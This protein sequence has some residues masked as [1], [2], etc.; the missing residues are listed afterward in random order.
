MQVSQELCRL[1]VLFRLG[2]HGQL[3]HLLPRLVLAPHQLL[4]VALV[5]GGLLRRPSRPCFRPGPGLGLFPR[6][7]PGLRACQQ[8]A[9]GPP[10]LA[11]AVPA[12]RDSRRNRRT[13]SASTCAPSP[14]ATI[15][16]NLSFSVVGSPVTQSAIPSSLTGTSGPLAFAATAIRSSSIFRNCATEASESLSSLSPAGTGGS[17]SSARSLVLVEPAQLDLEQPPQVEQP[18]VPGRQLAAGRE[19]RVEQPP[20]LDPVVALIVVPPEPDDH[21]LRGLRHPRPVLLIA[22]PPRRLRVQQ[23]LWQPE[24]QLPRPPVRRVQV[25]VEVLLQ[26]PPGV[27]AEI[28]ERVLVGEPRS[29]D[30]RPA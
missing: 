13:S 1:V 19:Q 17:A 2:E 30:L 11:V 14:S 8:L 16:R 27:P 5:G 23:R 26:Q 29:R 21:V 15:V 22:V 7:P 28:P 20:A 10:A 12:G 25:G 6:G 4:Q 24:R 3:L 18:Q 9:R